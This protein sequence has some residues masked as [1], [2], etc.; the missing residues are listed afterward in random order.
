MFRKKS[1]RN[2]KAYVITVLSD[3]VRRVFSRLN[4][5]HTMS[6]IAAVLGALP[7]LPDSDFIVVDLM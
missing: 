4:A 5:Y 6:N 7:L 1:R 2:Q 3:S